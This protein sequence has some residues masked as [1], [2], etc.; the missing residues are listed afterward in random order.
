MNIF[1]AAEMRVVDT[2]ATQVFGLHPSLLMENAALRL[3]EFLEAKFAP[4]REKKVV[5][6]CGKGNNGGDGLAAA[7]HL[8]NG[9][10]SA[11]TVIA[12]PGVTVPLNHRLDV[13]Q[14]EDSFSPNSGRYREVESLLERAD[15]VVD[16]LLGTGAAG[17]ARPPYDE[18]LSMLWSDADR[19]QATV[20]VDLPSGL[21]ANTGEFPYRVP[22]AS[23]QCSNR[24][25]ITFAAPKPGLMLREGLELAGEVWIGDIGDPAELFNRQNIKAST[26]GLKEAQSQLRRLRRPLDSNKGQAGRV[27]IIGGSWG[28]SGAPILAA[29]AA[30]CAGTGLC[31][32][33]VPEKVLPIF[34]TA[35]FEA[36]SHGLP[37]DSEGRFTE[38]AFHELTKLW[39]NVQVVALGPGISRSDGA[40]ALVRHVVRDCPHPLII[41]AD[42]LYA[43]KAEPQLVKNRTEPTI[44]TPHPGEMGELMGLTAKEVNG[45]RFAVAAACAEKYGALV[46]LKGSRSVVARPDGELSVNLSGNSGMATGGSGDALTGTVAGLLAQLKDPHAALQLGVYLHGFAGDIAYRTLG[47]GLTA[48]DIVSNIAPALLE[49]AQREPET[50]NPR[51]RRLE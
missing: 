18:L 8:S 30:L 24:F 2:D 9:G 48:S 5:V 12:A 47:N 19:R 44:L 21:N 1:T 16:A 27:L 45:E 41:D 40:L 46:D 25:T 39:E 20:F 31:I 17:L 11:L 34:A 29:R 32:A 38:E 14:L 13:V 22:S 37:C 49:V 28:M 50:I 26:F 7:R 4:L 36:T 33:A 35:C 51:L 15:V 6:L 42:A 43:L 3:V 23:S 10:V